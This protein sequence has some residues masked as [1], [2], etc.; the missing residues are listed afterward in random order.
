MGEVPRVVLHV[1]VVVVRVLVAD[2]VA[3]LIVRRMLQIAGG[4]S[5]KKETKTESD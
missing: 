3:E 5:G 4:G 1:A 2:L